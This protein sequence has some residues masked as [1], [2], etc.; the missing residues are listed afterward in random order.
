MNIHDVKR[1]AFAMSPGSDR[2]VSRELLIASC[3]T[4]FS[5]YHN[6]T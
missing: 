2:R 3:R 6:P 4:D 1:N 5:T